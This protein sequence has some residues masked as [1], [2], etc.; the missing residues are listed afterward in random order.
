MITVWRYNRSHHLI[1]ATTLTPRAAT[2]RWSRIPLAHGWYR[3]T[4]R[5]TNATGTGATTARS[6]LVVAR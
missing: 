1:R 2:T 6:N 5:A 4:V 3:F